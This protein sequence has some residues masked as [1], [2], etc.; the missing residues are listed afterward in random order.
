MKKIVSK[1]KT[2]CA[3]IFY[4]FAA[5]HP[6]LIRTVT[7]LG[8]GISMAV[9]ETNATVYADSDATSKISDGIGAMI[10][11]ATTVVLGVGVIMA[12][13]AVF[14][15]ISA[16]HEEDSARQSKSIIRVVIALILILIKPIAH[17][18]IKAIGD[19]TANEYTEDWG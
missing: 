14:N 4:K 15:W 9:V 7:A 10:S 19:D 1:I 3:N 13:M 8:F 12:I 18:I 2:S 6:K 17:V 16:I 11:I 5:K